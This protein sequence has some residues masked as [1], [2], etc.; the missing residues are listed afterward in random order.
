MCHSIPAREPC[1]VS[2]M[3]SVPSP[4]PAVLM[5][6]GAAVGALPQAEEALRPSAGGPPRAPQ[7]PCLVRRP[8]GT[9]QARRADPMQ[10]T[11]TCDLPAVVHRAEAGV[12]MKLA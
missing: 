3:P 1:H 6:I 10:M 9:A 11:A 12:P 2:T 7:T 5:R 8:T 4:A